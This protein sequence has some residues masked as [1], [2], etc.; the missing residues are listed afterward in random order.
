MVSR[1]K[2]HAFAEPVQQWFTLI[3]YLLLATGREAQG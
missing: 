2:P 3:L 1:D